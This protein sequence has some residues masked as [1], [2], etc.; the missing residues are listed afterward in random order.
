L[1][2]VAMGTKSNFSNSAVVALIF[3]VIN[4]ISLSFYYLIDFFAQKMS[5]V[6]K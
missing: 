5:L 1:F 6:I 4:F 3:L 2:L